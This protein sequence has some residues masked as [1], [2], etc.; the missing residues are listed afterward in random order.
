[1]YH[2]SVITHIE[3]AQM[4][5]NQSVVQTRTPEMTTSAHFLMNYVIFEQGMKTYCH[6]ALNTPENKTQATLATHSG[7][8]RQ[9]EG[10]RGER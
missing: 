3:T 6:V 4:F 5:Q 9:R 1:M 8:Q 10:R 7:Q 2:E